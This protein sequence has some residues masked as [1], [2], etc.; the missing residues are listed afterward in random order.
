MVLHI[1]LA[2]ESG[3]WIQR[4]LSARKEIRLIPP[5]QVCGSESKSKRFDDVEEGLRRMDH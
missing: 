3:Q 1:E 4:N 5:W 2:Y